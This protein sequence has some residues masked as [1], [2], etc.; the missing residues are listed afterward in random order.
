M[1]IQAQHAL[2]SVGWVHHAAGHDCHRFSVHWMEQPWHPTETAD[3]PS[4]LPVL[5]FVG[6]A[7]QQIRADYQPAS[8]HAVPL[9]G[10]S[11]EATAS[12]C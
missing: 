3:E 6:L 5:Q 11:V 9:L 8:H 12:C 1:F 7:M 10:E 2:M 4:L